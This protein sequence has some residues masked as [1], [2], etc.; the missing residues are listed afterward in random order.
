LL[1]TIIAISGH[2]RA[3]RLIGSRT[4]NPLRHCASQQW[5]VGISHHVRTSLCIGFPDWCIGRVVLLR[6]N[7]SGVV[8]KSPRLTGFCLVHEGHSCGTAPR[9]ALVRCAQDSSG[10]P[11]WLPD[12]D[13]HQIAQA[14]LLA[15]VP[16]FS[17]SSMIRRPPGVH[18]AWGWEGHNWSGPRWVWG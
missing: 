2:T 7:V 4:S 5:P 1:G 10:S 3:L 12:R 6:E 18:L 14:E 16:S 13:G 17:M 11:P 15:Q 8:L 9:R